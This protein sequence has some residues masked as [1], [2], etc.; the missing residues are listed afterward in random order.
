ME[1]K[2]TQ[3][4]FKI[5]LDIDHIGNTQA[6]DN[7]EEILHQRGL[8]DF[9]QFIGKSLIDARAYAQKDKSKSKSISFSRQHNTITIS[10]SRGS[11]KTTFLLNMLDIIQNQDKKCPSSLKR[12]EANT[13][14]VLEILDPT[15]IEDKEHVFVNIISRIKETVDHR[16]QDKER[17]ISKT[18]YAT[19]KNSLKELA[20]GL[21]ALDGIGGHAMD[22]DAWMDPIHVMEK[23]LSKVRSSNELEKNFHQYIHESLKLIGKEAFLLPLDDIDTKF[24]S[25]WQVLE[26]LRKYLTTPQLITVLSGDLGLY[27]KLVRRH[28]WDNFGDRLLKQEAYDQENYR[29]LVDELEEQY[30]FKILKPERRVLLMTIGEQLKEPHNEIWVKVPNKETEEENFTDYFER[31]CKEGLQQSPLPQEVARLYQETLL[32]APIRFI[33]QLL[34]AYHKQKGNLTSRIPDLFR[35]PLH[36]LGFRDHFFRSASHR[37]YL[38]TVVVALAKKG[39]LETGYTMLPKTVSPST[40]LGMIAL[41]ALTTEMMTTHPGLMFDC[42]VKLGLTREITRSLPVKAEPGLMSIEEYLSH[43][44]L[45]SRSDALKHTHLSA[46]YL[47]TKDTNKKGNKEEDRKGNKEVPPEGRHTFCQLGTIQARVQ[48][49]GKTLESEELRDTTIKALY[50]VSFPKTEKLKEAL[51]DDFFMIDEIDKHLINPKKNTKKEASPK[52]YAYDYLFQRKNNFKSATNDAGDKGYWPEKKGSKPQNLKLLPNFYFHLLP[53]LTRSL[54]SWQAEFIPPLFST[55]QS[56]SGE[57]TIIFSAHPLLAI[58][59]KFLEKNVSDRIEYDDDLFNSFI[60]ELATP[61]ESPLPTRLGGS[62]DVFKQSKDEIDTKDEDEDENENEIFQTEVDTAATTTTERS[63]FGHLLHDWVKK[64]PDM[65]ATKVRLTPHFVG[66]ISDR[67]H[68]ALDQIGQTLEAEHHALGFMTHR[69]IVAFL[70]AVLVEEAIFGNIP[71]VKIKHPVTTDYIFEQNLKAIK[72][73]PLSLFRWIFAC[74]IWGLFL[75][76]HELQTPEVNIPSQTPLIKIYLNNLK[77]AGLIIQREK[78]NSDGSKEIAQEGDMTEA[79]FLKLLRVDFYGVS[80]VFDNLFAPLN[81]VLLRN[82]GNRDDAK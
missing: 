38:N 82:V 5:L 55:S 39:A 75:Q 74:P 46:V 52:K 56:A 2:S 12:E 60:R 21:T 19:W 57:R 68:R 16:Y 54:T 30:L 41:S 42:I 1:E 66:R 6:F 78:Y 23:G 4:A 64:S 51:T 40:N 80:G 15:L 59:G 25:G 72:E 8:T 32:N 69:Y 34:L 29:R 63:N 81:S 20:G 48:H 44:E 49:K 13:I 76:I 47:R 28:Q 37:T 17:E 31:L 73:E 27:S 67:F 7:S 35:Q 43:T 26:V 50:G 24:E 45:E 10:G 71:G 77:K 22:S 62:A 3:T 9:F 65:K 61:N 11:G 14:E 36:N 70:N 53:D 79:N 58:I 33:S 18:E